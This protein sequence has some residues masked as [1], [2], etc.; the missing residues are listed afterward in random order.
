[1]KLT[2]VVKHRFPILFF[3]LFFVAAL[4]HTST[5]QQL[6][7]QDY[8]KP[9]PAS[10]YEGLSFE[11]PKDPVPEFPDYS[12]SIEEFGAVPDG[13]TLNTDAI[14]KAIKHVNEQGWG[15]VVIP[16]GI[17][18][19]GPIMLKSNINLHA[20]KGALIKIGRASCREGGE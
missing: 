13:N 9:V 6:E 16:R 1:M 18:K 4:V 5:V 2:E 8:F 14:R 3:F 15:R 17:W 7:E 20:E 12:D 10:F 19:T 11:M